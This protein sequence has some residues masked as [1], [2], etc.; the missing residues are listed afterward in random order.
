MAKMKVKG[1]KTL[2]C[3]VACSVVLSSCVG[4][5]SLFNHLAQWNKKATRSKI[6]NE[7][8][9]LVISPA[10][11][12]CGVADVLVLNTIEFWSGSNPM[13][14]NVGKTQNV[15]GNDGKLY[16]VKTL[17]DGYQI[18]TPEGAVSLF[19]YDKKTN[20]WSMTVNGKTTEI[21]RFNDDG[22][23]QASLNNGQKINV[24]V[25]EE[26]IYETRL[27]VNGGLYYAMR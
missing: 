4:S 12:V 22:T 26:G 25:S 3:L 1:L 7:L 20:S 5:F 15:L 27:A 2:V 16:A 8:I 11:A 9:F 18:T 17:K 19:S 23:I 6:L 14:S 21:F 10:Y 13:A 24:P